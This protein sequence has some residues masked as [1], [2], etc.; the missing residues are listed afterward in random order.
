MRHATLA[1]LCLPLACNPGPQ[2]PATTATTASATAPAPSAAGPSGLT[3]AG[4]GP[5]CP[6][7]AAV[8]SQ[9]RVHDGYEV[10]LSPDGALI[11]T[12]D[13]DDLVVLT[14]VATGQHVGEVLGRGPRFT[15][16]GRALLVR[17]GAS[18]I[19]H[20]LPGLAARVVMTGPPRL[21][22]LA[23]DDAGARV[24]A[25]DLGRLTVWDTASGARRCED[26][27][28]SASGEVAI[29]GDGGRVFTCADDQ[30]AAW[31]T[32][33]CRPLATTTLSG[34]CIALALDPTGA[35]L[36]AQ[37]RKRSNVK[38]FVGYL[39]DPD[40][41]PGAGDPPPVP[42]DATD[43]RDPT[44]LARR[45]VWP[46]AGDP[47]RSV[48]RPD[49]RAL[50]GVANLGPGVVELDLDT[51]ATSDLELAP[52]TTADSLAFSADGK[53]LAVVGADYAPGRFERWELRDLRV[54]S[55]PERALVSAAPTDAIKP[56]SP[57]RP[58]PHGQT[59]I[60]FETDELEQGIRRLDTWEPLRSTFGV[61]FRF[62]FAPGGEFLAAAASGE[63][64]LLDTRS[65]AARDPLK[66]AG[67]IRELAFS[68][69]ASR[70]LLATDDGRLHVVDVASFQPARAFTG[71][72]VPARF[73]L[74]PPAE[75]PPPVVP[76]LSPDGA[77]VLFARPNE[78]PALWDVASGDRLQ[79]LDAPA[80]DAE[81]SADGARIAL[82]GGDAVKVFD[83]RTGEAL[84]TVAVQAR[85]ALLSRDGAHLVTW[86]TEDA[87][88]VH[89]LRGG[90]P[91]PL[92]D[93]ARDLSFARDGALLITTDTQ[94][95]AHSLATGSE[96]ARIDAPWTARVVRLA[97]GRWLVARTGRLLVHAADG[98]LL[99][100]RIQARDGAWAA[101]A[102]DGTWDVGD[103]RGTRLLAGA[104]NLAPCSGHTRH[105]PGLWTRALAGAP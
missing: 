38:N 80:L 66:L 20:E 31:D 57:I 92:A 81:W 84:A 72:D 91:R 37:T 70:L 74:D 60:T 55:W 17:R 68:D 15:R 9:A 6:D 102:P 71:V 29:S 2:A 14:D 1:A 58:L 3:L 24:A 85:T 61:P 33:T 41:V 90:P 39:D 19:R 82:R 89:D 5:A 96:L 83:V 13:E 45:A 7:G 62:A 27:H 63:A 53:R 36:V 25:V 43:V 100:S 52:A 88:L 30:L 11:A 48:F 95:I 87:V 103:P 47:R 46:Q 59:L 42:N 54:W 40:V 51:G 77:R 50:L 94:R 12:V 18:L 16:D 75:R 26:A 10:A 104:T 105:Q 65:G 22:N 64:R 8:V 4:R 86:T 23:V 21:R 28:A 98:A 99:A 79:P 101:W 73:T 93:G 97:D 76:T 69:D 49:G 44:T 78:G 67:D 35:R 56:V 32:A 34:T